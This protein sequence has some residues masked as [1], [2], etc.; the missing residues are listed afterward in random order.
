MTSAAIV[1]Y[2]ELLT[3]EV[4]AESQQQLDEGMAR[5]G[6]F[7]GERPLCTVLRPRF[8]APAQYRAMQQRAAVVLRAFDRAY[9]VAMSNDRVRAQFRLVDWEER[10]VH[11]HPRFRDASPTSRLDAFF[12]QGDGDA[13]LKFTEYNAET[14]AGAGFNDVL[15]EMFFGFA[16]MRRFM[17]RY[18]VLPLPARPGVMHALLNAYA[19][20][21]GSARKRPNVGILDW[22]EVPTAREFTIFQEFFASHGIP[23]VIGDPRECEYADGRLTVGGAPIDLIYKRVLLSE[24]V[25]RCGEESA[26]IRAV[27]DGAA[28]MVNPFQCK[29]L[30]KKASL[31][32]LSDE[33]NAQFFTADERQAIDEHIPFTRVV[34]ERTTK[35]GGA[36]IDLIPFTLAN[37]ETLVL[38]PNDEYG[39]KGIVLGWEVDDAEWESSLAVAIAEPYIVQERIQLPTEPYPN[40]VDGAVQILDRMVDTA[41]FCFDGA[42]VAGCMTRIGTTSLLNVTAGGGS[43]VPTFLVEQR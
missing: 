12:T 22:R 2:H 40:Y 29:I 34:E 20:F 36:E 38:K 10:L 6:L 5:H 3:D 17:R 7:F 41:P 21:A 1:R 25:E 23:C 15:T 8:L 24:L 9:Q 43:N 30:H 16:V 11:V 35:K 37:R 18:N 39:G 19:Q 28:C 13:G 32:V 42:Y 33:R 14:P 31:A 26:V 27:K 4:A